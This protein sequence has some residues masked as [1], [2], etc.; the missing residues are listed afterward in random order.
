MNTGVNG[1]LRSLLLM[2]AVAMMVIISTWFITGLGAEK[3]IVVA[4]GLV[5][6]AITVYTII[7]YEF[8]FYVA[9]VLGHIIFFA[10][11]LMPDVLPTA[12]LVDLQIN[13]TFIGLLVHKVVR[14]ESFLKN[15][16]HTITFAYLFY[17][18]FLILQVFNPEM[19]SVE[20][21]F[22]VLRKF[23]QFL[24]I[25]LIALNMFTDL[26]K[27]RYFLVFWGVCAFLSGLYGCYQQWF[28]FMGFEMDWIWAVPGRSGLYALDNGDFRKF[29]TLSGPAAYGI[30]CGASA[31]LTAVLG[32]REKKWG[33]KIAWF[34]AATFSL[35]GMAY[36]GTR[37][38]YLIF[39]AGI[40]LY[41]LMTI[42]NRSTLII[43]S[44]FFMGF[45]VVMWGP[46]YGNVTINR[47]RTAFDTNDASLNVRDVNRALIQPYI[48]AHP[49]GGGLASSGVQGLNYNPEHL[50]AG[51]PPDSGFVKTAIESGWIGFFLQC[52]LYCIILL[53]GVR[54][55]YRA[56]TRIVRVYCLAAL[57]TIFGFVISQYGQVSIGQIPD[58][59]LFYSLLAIIVRLGKMPDHLLTE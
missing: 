37:T 4:M 9:V 16:N 17:T 13:A 31:L 19:Q 57:V 30:L 15:A 47:I 18:F 7:N 32:T 51:F 54:V 27:I 12:L 35:L 20:G 38:A 22:F 55:F 26:K 21:W 23:L 41:V 5:G 10:D 14:H 50:L 56:Q 43:A 52:L 3:G 45:V 36:A 1:N 59:F 6:L 29:G 2:S 46:I 8:G 24:M 40:V 25:Y 42:T 44:L 33:N 48:H 11:R 28:G 58:C 39:T 53:S 49:L 34:I